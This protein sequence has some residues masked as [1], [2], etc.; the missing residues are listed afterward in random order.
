MAMGEETSPS[1]L[2]AIHDGVRPLVSK[3]Q[4]EACVSSAEKTGA[5]ILAVP[6]SDT[7]KQVG[8]N[9]NFIS[10]TLE[11]EGLWLAQTPQVFRYHIIRSAHENALREGIEATDDAMLVEMSGVQIQI[12]PGNRKNIKITTPED[13]SLGEFILCRET[14]DHVAS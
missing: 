8:D 14:G 7:I 11:R 6:V 1:D 4:I 3:S 9:P 2:V 5:S 10:R 13:L 12:V